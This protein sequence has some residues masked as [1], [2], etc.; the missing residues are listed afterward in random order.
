M[1]KKLRIKEVKKLF[2]SIIFQFI[3]LIIVI[4]LSVVNHTFTNLEAITIN[5]AK[6][7]SKFVDKRVVLNPT[8]IVNYYTEIVEDDG[9]GE[10]LS[11][12]Y[13]GYNVEDDKH[14]GILVDKDLS[15][16]YESALNAY[17]DFDYENAEKLVPRTEGT[18]KK[19]DSKDIDFFRESLESV[20]KEDLVMWY[21]SD[22]T[23]EEIE[24]LTEE[25]INE[26]IS[27]AEST[28]FTIEELDEYAEY[29]YIDYKEEGD[30][31]TEVVIYSVFIVVLSIFILFKLIKFL[32]YTKF[33]HLKDKIE[34]DYNIR[35]EDLEQDFE[36]AINIDTV[37][38]GRNYSVFLTKK[39]ADFIK[40]E[41]IIWIYIQE[42]YGHYRMGQKYQYSIVYTDKNGNEHFAKIN[43]KK[44]VKVLETYKEKY[45][46][47]YVGYNQQLYKILK[48]NI[49][50]FY[51]FD[52]EKLQ[53]PIIKKI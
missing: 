1:L 17:S 45:P 27:Y 5:N 43:R 24:N 30:Y 4:V 29:Y 51:E 15:N 26:V 9:K 7:L 12:G 34:A 20:L 52:K 50:E 32:S 38:I 2:T 28:E 3:F 41:D 13:I 8:Y 6:D 48:E 36:N 10:V 22:L 11:L 33:K 42:E 49:N 16:E 46:N 18:V 39:S 40:N 35:Q 14:F 21:L 19:M 23:D 53:M 44:A 47:L 25:Q 37:W 31:I